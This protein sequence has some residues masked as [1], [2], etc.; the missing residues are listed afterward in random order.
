MSKIF[1][2]S[3]AALVLLFFG[4]DA[5]AQFRVSGNSSSG[6]R[7]FSYS[8]NPNIAYFNPESNG[9]W[10]P[11]NALRNLT[12]DF[13]YGLPSGLDDSLSRRRLVTVSDPYSLIGSA[14]PAFG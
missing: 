12:S 11:Y 7:F 3:A 5:S 8:S 2:P 4:A 13:Y 10:V 14:F 9:S 6:A 1:V